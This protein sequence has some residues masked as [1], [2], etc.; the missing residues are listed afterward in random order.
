M[1]QVRPDDLSV[2]NEK[3]Q[4]LT[5]MLVQ[6][7]TTY[8]RPTLLMNAN[9]FEVSEFDGFVVLDYQLYSRSITNQQVR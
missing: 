7:K 1:I 2:A 8:N 5:S 6:G 3:E 9:Q 4:L